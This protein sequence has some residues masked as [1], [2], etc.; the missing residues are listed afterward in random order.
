LIFF[1][2]EP[3]R[4]FSPMAT[5]QEDQ[6]LMVLVELIRSYARFLLPALGVGFGNELK[7][8]LIAFAIPG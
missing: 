5:A 6:P 7:Q 8:I 2:E 4:D 3:N 1:F